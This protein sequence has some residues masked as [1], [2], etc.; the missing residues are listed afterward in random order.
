MTQWFPPNFNW[1]FCQRRHFPSPPVGYWQSVY[2]SNRTGT[3]L[4]K[5]ADMLYLYSMRLLSCFVQV[6][7][8]DPNG[9]DPYH[10]FS[11]VFTLSRHRRTSRW[12]RPS[13]LWTICARASIPR[14]VANWDAKGHC[15]WMAGSVLFLAIPHE[16]KA[17]DICVIS[18]FSTSQPLDKILEVSQ[19]FQR[20]RVFF[21]RGL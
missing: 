20:C 21:G 4:V 17:P 5:L 9:P 3:I 8:T 10:R 6:C 13:R 15:L 7:L 19:Q 14:S 11:Y 18:F 1:I 2:F 12:R 16:L